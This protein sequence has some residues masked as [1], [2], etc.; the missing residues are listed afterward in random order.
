MYYDEKTIGQFTLGKVVR[1]S[2]GSTK[3]AI[4]HVVGFAPNNVDELIISVKLAFNQEVQDIHPS[5]L[6]IL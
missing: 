1:F 6:E 5:N 2:K 4:G 3:G